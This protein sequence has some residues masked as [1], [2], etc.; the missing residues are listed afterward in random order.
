MDPITQQLVAT[1][2][3]MAGV[4]GYRENTDKARAILITMA[5][6]SKL[7]IF[8]LGFYLI[9]RTAHHGDVVQSGW[10]CS[11]LVELADEFAASEVH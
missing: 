4:A 11:A 3:L 1:Q 6:Q 5:R 9:E 8:D 10:F 7:P 2:T